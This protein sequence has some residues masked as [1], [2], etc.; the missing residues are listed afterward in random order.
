MVGTP[1]HRQ[2]YGP[3]E[4]TVVALALMALAAGMSAQT[5]FVPCMPF[6]GQAA[7][8][9]LFERELQFPEDALNE[10]VDG[11]STLIFIVD[12]DGAVRELRIWQ[13]LSPSC[14]AEALR[15]ARLVRWHPATVDGQP[16]AAE[17]YLK[18]PFEQKLY[19][20]WLKARGALCAPLPLAPTDPSGAILGRNEVDS[21][22]EPLLPGGSKSLPAYLV[23][24]LRYPPDAYRRD[25]QGTVRLEF[26][27]EPSGSLSNLRALDELGAGCTDEAMR[28]IRSLCWKP[29]VKNGVRVRGTQ[30]IS[31]D[32]RIASNQH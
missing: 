12:A 27:V 16:R 26:V 8:D 7:V 13:P 18:V 11:V 32:F 30:V 24:N 23:Q 17:H 6:G 5:G 22:P 20:K 2:I 15:L 1:I 4:R 29:A 3:M 10:G 21:L 19:R 31:I 14:D 28:L 25:L 9:A